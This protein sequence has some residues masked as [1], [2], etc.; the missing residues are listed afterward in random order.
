MN[1]TLCSYIYIL[2]TLLQMDRQQLQKFAQYLISHH[3]TEV[4]PTAQQLADTI[5]KVFIFI[6]LLFVPLTIIKYNYNQLDA[7]IIYFIREERILISTVQM[8]HPIQQLEGMVVM[9]RQPG[10]SMKMKL[11][12]KSRS[13]WLNKTLVF[14]VQTNILDLCFPR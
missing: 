2:E 12:S 5:L 14:I 11:E 3:H 1:Q 6:Y 10:I 8:V 4:L 13:T 7:N 9:M